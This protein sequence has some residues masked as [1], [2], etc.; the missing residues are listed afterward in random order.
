MALDPDFAKVALAFGKAANAQ[1]FAARIEE[2]GYNRAPIEWKGNNLLFLVYKRAL[3]QEVMA[4]AKEY[5][6][7]VPAKPRPLS[8][9]LSPRR[10]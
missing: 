1:A 4:I 2:Q 6:A 5:R 7:Y 8:P 3:E 9:P 10:R